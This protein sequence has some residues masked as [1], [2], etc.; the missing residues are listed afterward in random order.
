MQA[1]EKGGQRLSEAAV[2][3]AMSLSTAS[4]A[5]LSMS[6]AGLVQPVWRTLDLPSM[7]IF[8]GKFP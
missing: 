5:E 2:K 1:Y 7:C 3:G 4:K 6:V 8:N